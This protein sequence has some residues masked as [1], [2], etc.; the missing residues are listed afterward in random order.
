MSR[1]VNSTSQDFSNVSPIFLYTDNCPH[2]SPHYTY[3]FQSASASG[4]G[5]HL[6][7]WPEGKITRTE[8]IWSLAWQ[9][10]KRK[11]TMQ[12]GEE[13]LI[14]KQW[15]IQCPPK[16]LQSILVVKGSLFWLPGHNLGRSEGS[17][18]VSLKC[19]KKKKNPSTENSV[20][21]KTILP[22]WGRN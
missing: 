11:S 6:P 9:S 12:V 18:M 20:S 8:T 19:C 1:L 15:L 14:W 7:L 21:G 10:L 17:Q 4:M 16:E 22:K 2:L 13:K 3:P 5:R